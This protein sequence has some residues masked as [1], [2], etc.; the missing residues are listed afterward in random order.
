MTIADL[1]A[2]AWLPI[3]AGVT[4]REILL[5]GVDERRVPAPASC[6]SRA[7]RAR[8][9]KGGLAAHA[10]A[11]AHIIRTAVSGRPA[12]VFTSTISSGA[13]LM[14]DALE[15]GFDVAPACHVTIGK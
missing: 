1:A 8:A 9:D 3:S 5:L 13:E 4:G 10:A 14:P 7:H 6:Q 15:F 12:L 11:L 2:G